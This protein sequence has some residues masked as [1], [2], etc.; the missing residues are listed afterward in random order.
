MSSSASTR[1]STEGRRALWHRAID[2]AVI[3]ALGLA[4]GVIFWAWGKLYGAIDLGVT[5]GYPPL[6]GL[7]AGPWLMAGIVGGLIVRRRGAAFGTELLAASV[8]MFVLGGT[9]WGFTVVLAGIAQGAGA[10][11]AFALGRYRRF[12]VGVAILAGALAAVVESFYEWYFYYP[13]WDMAYKLAYLGFF[14]ASG[15]LVGVLSWLLVR[16]LAQT[17]ALDSFGAGRE[18]A[19]EDVRV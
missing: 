7:L 3:V 15:A 1:P 2:L 12:G 6:S 19:G 9:E 18:A 5:L 16:S 10:E 14:A 4:F 13:D 8:S 11:L 17:G